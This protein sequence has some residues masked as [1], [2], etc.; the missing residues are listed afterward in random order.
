MVEGPAGLGR[1]LSSRLPHAPASAGLSPHFSAC[2]VKQYLVLFKFHPLL[3]E[4]LRETAEW[5]PSGRPSDLWRP[6]H[7]AFLACP[8]QSPQRG[9][10]HPPILHSDAWEC[11]EGTDPDATSS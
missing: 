4:K 5:G 9:P 8:H 10:H 3:S 6:G 1:G 11:G 2:Y 7:P